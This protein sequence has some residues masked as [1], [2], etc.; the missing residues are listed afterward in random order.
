MKEMH[1][2][3]YHFREAQAEAEAH[4]WLFNKGGIVAL[5][6]VIDTGKTLMLWRIQDQLR[7]EGQIGVSESLVFD[8]PRVTVNTLKLALYYDLATDQLIPAYSP[9]V[10]AGRVRHSHGIRVKIGQCNQVDTPMKSS[11][12]T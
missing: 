9:I 12:Y 2:T 1:E 7:Q 11:R 8:V 5:T 10:S 4:A 3:L 6:G